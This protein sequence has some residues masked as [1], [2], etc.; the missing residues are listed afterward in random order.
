MT[1]SKGS[2]REPM[3]SRRTRLRSRIPSL[4]MSERLVFARVANR[5]RVDINKIPKPPLMSKKKESEDDE[6]GYSTAS[7][8]SP[9]PVRSSRRS[10][11]SLRS[12]PSASAAAAAAVTEVEKARSR[13][14]EYVSSS[15]DEGGR[16]E[17]S[18]RSEERSRR[19]QRSH[20]SERSHRSHRSERSRVS[21]GRKSKRAPLH[22]VRELS[23][24]DESDSDSETESVRLRREEADKKSLLDQLEEHMIDL[25]MRKE[26]KDL[27]YWREKATVA[28][29][30]KKISDLE[31]HL[32]VRAEKGNFVDTILTT[33]NILETSVK[34]FSRWFDLDGLKDCIQAK[35]N[36]NEV[37]L[38][39][40]IQKRTKTGLVAN[41]MM[42][43]A[44]AIGWGAFQFG[45]EKL[46]ERV[47]AKYP[48]ASA[49]AAIASAALSF[50]GVAPAEAPASKATPPTP[51]AS[52][53][54]LTTSGGGGGGGGGAASPDPPKRKM[55]PPV[56]T[57][58]FVQ[59][60]AAATDSLGES[61]RS[62]ISVEVSKTPGRSGLSTPIVE[63]GESEYD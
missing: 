4:T 28:E 44:K 54:T 13:P 30:R 36:D 43:L 1:K 14:I 34:P 32:L 25:R 62:S 27:P 53:S 57:P 5:D 50:S 56:D 6:D 45:A 60:S 21:E 52:A 35:L 26:E 37:L 7:S 41:P 48:A 51:S 22:S 3:D 11:V 8:P 33:A 47:G 17:R 55:R 9:P 49:T 42:A 63:V 24:S 31:T 10:R 15:D 23:S 59:K 2:L 58:V 16:S 39:K 38:R 20:R 19:S 40:V 12:K 29:I 46:K 18:Y 61:M